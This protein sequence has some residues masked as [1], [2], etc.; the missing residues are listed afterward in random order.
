[1][2]CASSMSRDGITVSAESVLNDG[3]IAAVLLK[4]TREDGGPLVQEEAREFE[5]L[6]FA[7]GP[8]PEEDGVHVSGKI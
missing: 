2:P 1:M 7:S 4:V 8:V 5:H 6:I 3:K